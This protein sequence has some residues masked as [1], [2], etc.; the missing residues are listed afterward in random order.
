MRRETIGRIRNPK[1]M[2][3]KIMRQIILGLLILAVFFGLD[4][5]SQEEVRGLEGALFYISI[6]QFIMPLNTEIIIYQIE[7]TVF[8]REYSEKLYRI[9]PYFF[10][11]VIVELPLLLLGAF[12]FSVCVYFGIGT[13]VNFYYFLRFLFAIALD[14][15]AGNSYGYLISS[16]FDRAETAVAMVPFF[17]L[18]LS[19]L[20]GLFTSSGNVPAWFAWLQWISPVRYTFEALIYNEF[21]HRTDLGYL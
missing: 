6:N 17:I 3:V 1:Q 8:L 14:S 16:L 5:N 7:R 10:S 19:I 4:G 15:F 9:I 20:G 2:R 18:P 12:L 11:K 13:T 21:S